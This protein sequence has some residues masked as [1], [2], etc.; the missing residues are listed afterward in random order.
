PRISTPCGP[1]RR[2]EP[3]EPGATMNRPIPRT[4]EGWLL[5]I[6]QAIRDARE[7]KPFGKLIGQRITDAKW[8]HLA[9]LVCLKFRGR[10]LVGRE[11]DRLTRTAL[12]NSIVNSDTGGIDHGGSSPAPCPHRLGQAL[13]LSSHLCGGQTHPLAVAG[14]DPLEARRRQPSHR[15]GL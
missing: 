5:E 15:L 12:A 13:D 11:A 7:A 6:R 10:K 2:D 8:F 4:P 14:Q 1:G 9:P 3:G